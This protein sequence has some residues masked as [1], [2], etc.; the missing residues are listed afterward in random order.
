M[1]ERLPSFSIIVPTFRRPRQVVECVEALARLDYPPE[2]YKVIV[3]ESDLSSLAES[4]RE[5]KKRIRLQVI[6][7]PAYGQAAARNLGVQAAHGEFLA[8]TDDDCRPVPSWLRSLAAQFAVTPDRVV[9]GP[10][11]NFLTNDPY[12]T[13]TQIVI[14]CLYDWYNSNPNMPRYFGTNNLAVPVSRFQ[15]LGG[16]DSSFR[17]AGEDRDFCARWLEH[18]Y[19]MAFSPEAIVWHAHAMTLATFWQQ[20]FNYGR[21]SFR[22]RAARTRVGQR[23]FE[24]EPFAFY[25]KMLSAPF[26]RLSRSPYPTWILIILLL[27]SQSA[28]AAGFLRQTLDLVKPVEK[29][30]SAPS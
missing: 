11:C 16:F 5:Y 17:P 14:D 27:I 19:Q 28:T 8:F 21:G 20:H 15:A 9:G 30:T 23:T 6:S 10:V 4:L 1:G 3:V 22:F 12:A 24:L 7:Q 25:R 2:L 26:S 18:G 13:L 29:K